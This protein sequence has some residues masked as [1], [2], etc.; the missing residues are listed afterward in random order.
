[1]THYLSI[2][3]E[4]EGGYPFNIMDYGQSLW[5]EPWREETATPETVGGPWR[6]RDKPESVYYVS[7]EESDLMDSGA[8][9]HIT[10]SLDV[11]EDLSL[12]HI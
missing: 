5:V 11:L 9:C 6:E 8:T 4:D 10:N 3:Q 2:P 12:I 7:S 1:M